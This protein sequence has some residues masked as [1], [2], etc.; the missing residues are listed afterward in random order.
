MGGLKVQHVLP[1]LGVE[2]RRRERAGG[3]RKMER[4]RRERVGGERK[5]KGKGREREREREEGG[6]QFSMLYCTYRLDGSRTIH[7]DCIVPAQI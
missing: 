4:R 1:G 5:K 6:L 2:R 3:E 7:D